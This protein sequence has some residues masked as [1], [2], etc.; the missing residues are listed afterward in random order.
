MDLV[1]F[2][3][4]T[5]IK[6]VWLSYWWKGY[7]SHQLTFKRSRSESNYKTHKKT[8]ITHLILIFHPLLLALFSESAVPAGN[9]ATLTAGVCF[10][11][12]VLL[13]LRFPPPYPVSSLVMY[14]RW[15][16]RMTFDEFCMLIVRFVGCQHY[17]L[18][19]QSR[20][21][22]KIQKYL[23]LFKSLFPAHFY[24]YLKVVSTCS[25]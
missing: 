12:N 19:W 8:F 9:T 4:Q 21:N 6:F 15:H 25:F 24:Y 14:R 18:T 5:H 20:F 3:V 23:Q 11:S 13:R 10:C 1:C 2:Q 7:T 16:S 17:R 22:C